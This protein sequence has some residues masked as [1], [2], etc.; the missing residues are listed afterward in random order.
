M[1]DTANDK[2]LNDDNDNDVIAD[3]ETTTTTKKTSQWRKTR[4]TKVSEESQMRGQ[5]NKSALSELY[6]NM[7]RF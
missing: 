2:S 7:Q 5:F 4:T 6:K 1:A 3:E